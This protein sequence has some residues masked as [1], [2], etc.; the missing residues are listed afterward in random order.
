[1][2]SAAQRRKLAK[3]TDFERRALLE[4]AKI[5]R[6]ETRTYSEIAKR[7]GRPNAAR[8]VGN[9]LAKNP[10]PFPLWSA[11]PGTGKVSGSV[12]AWPSEEPET[13]GSG[14]QF[15]PCHRVVRKDG[16]GGYSAKGGKRAK[17]RMLGMERKR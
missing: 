17:E 3:L 1:M 13:F 2:L 10:L 16:M 8:A 12:S 7:I 6:G 11:K 15:I 9:A 5:P 4:C 14:K